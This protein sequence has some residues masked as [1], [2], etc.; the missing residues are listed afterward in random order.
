MPGS[1]EVRLGEF[2]HRHGADTRAGNMSH[3][4]PNGQDFFN[5]LKSKLATLEQGKTS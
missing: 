2:L 3:Q 5:L 4:M 1:L